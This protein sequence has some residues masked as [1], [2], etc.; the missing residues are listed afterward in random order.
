MAHD[1]PLRAA[2]YRP[3][4]SDRRP[5]RGEPE[6][7][8]DP[9]EAEPTRPAEQPA[10][11]SDVLQIA[12]ASSLVLAMLGFVAGGVL[13]RSDMFAGL[14]VA[15]VLMLLTV[16]L[17][18]SAGRAFPRFD[19]AS[20]VMLGLGA[21]LV[22]VQIRYYVIEGVYRGV[23][24]S[25]GYDQ[26]G[27]RLAP[28]FLDLD[29][30]VELG[31]SVLGTG[32]LRYLTGLVYVVVGSHQF[33]GFLVFGF[34]SFLGV[35]LMFRAFGMAVPDADL[36]RYALLA[37]LW[38]SM[39][40]WPSSVGKDSWMLLC[41]GVSCYGIARILTLRPGGFLIAGV[42][43]AG[44]VAVR[45]H[46]AILLGAAIV[47]A[48]FL[49]R[50][51][52]TSP[53]APAAKA[54]GLVVLLVGFAVVAAQAERFFGFEDLDSGS[55][56]E[57]LVETQGRTSQGGSAYTPVVVRNPL[58]Y[59]W[60][61]VTVLVRPFPTEADNGQMLF[62]SL[63]GFVLLLLIGLSIP[64]LGSIRQLATRHS[65]VVF[66]A[67]YVAMFCFAFAAMGNFGILARQRVQM[68]PFLFAL[69]SLP[70]AVRAVSSRGREPAP[71]YRTI[72]ER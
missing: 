3:T 23:G 37:F 55:V 10:H 2:T 29:F 41:I 58:Q 27:Q 13:W 36:R 39:I 25:T 52:R 60:A 44:V 5:S 63:E 31:R 12:A 14:I 67:V 49:R 59:P 38:P 72:N 19:A 42:G 11:R 17:A 6:A 62:T 28:Q 68:L 8:L 4:W 53:L 54:I 61:V 50:S 57:V 9:P 43:L 65:Y 1:G 20:I 16:P 18:R 26:W 7:R 56:E 21:K 40:F 70:Y 33:S 66:L 46:V 34:F 71:R 35:Y 47:P 45:P 64:R 30:T 24:D 69:L 32:F 22:G 48:Y 51:N 15:P